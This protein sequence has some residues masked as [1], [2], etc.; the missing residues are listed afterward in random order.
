MTAV[1]I[2]VLA[3][4]N[5]FFL[6]VVFLNTEELR[7]VQVAIYSFIGRYSNSWEH[8]FPIIFI[9]ILPV[10]LMYFFLQRY[11]IAGITAGSVKG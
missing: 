4:W 10:L 7:T 11:I 8:M 6:P 9:G 5:D 1:I 3:V 2:Q